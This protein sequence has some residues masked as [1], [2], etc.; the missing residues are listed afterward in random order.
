MKC[1]L[2]YHCN[3]SFQMVI[4]PFQQSRYYGIFCDV[5][6]LIKSL[7]ITAFGRRRQSGEISSFIS[8]RI[9]HLTIHICQF[10]LESCSKCIKHPPNFGLKV[11]FCVP[12]TAVIL[13]RQIQVQSSTRPVIL[14]TVF[15][16]NEKL[17]CIYELFLSPTSDVVPPAAGRA[18]PND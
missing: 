17:L 18:I 15:L 5:L 10:P 4:T 8:C 14:S 9:I 16:G 11:T 1:F 7:H 13:Q 2:F 3:E 6:I 12:V